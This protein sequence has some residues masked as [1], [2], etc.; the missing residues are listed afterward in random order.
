MEDQSLVQEEVWIDSSE[1]NSDQSFGSEDDGVSETEWGEESRFGEDD[2]RSVNG[3]KRDM[4]GYGVGVDGS[5]GDL[6]GAPAPATAKK[7]EQIADGNDDYVF[8]KE[9]GDNDF[10]VETIGFN[11]VEINLN[12]KVGSVKYSMGQVNMEK[13]M[14]FQGHLANS[15][16][17]SSGPSRDINGVQQDGPVGNLERAHQAGI[18]S[19]GHANGMG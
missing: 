19:E 17:S 12:G 14:D 18:Q 10:Y 1:E 9:A 3:G 2:G 8:K 5:T 16:E 13:N 11:E 7:A 15:G 4:Q 6:G